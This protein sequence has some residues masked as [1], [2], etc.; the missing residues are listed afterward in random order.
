MQSFGSK[1]AAA[2]SA[3]GKAASVALGAASTAAVAF[4]TNAVGVGKQFDE[5]MANVASISGAT[6]NAL[7]SLREKAIEMGGST[8]FSATEAADAMGYMAMAGWKTGDMLDGISGIMNLAAA[9]GTDLATTADI[10]TDALTAFGLSA[11]DSGH[12]ADVL[13][14][15]S[16]NA[17]TNVQMMG[18]TFKYV[19]PLAGALGLTAEDVAEAVGLMA[20]AGIKASQAGTALRA[21]LTRLTKPTGDMIPLMEKLGLAVSELSGEEAEAQTKA[22][23]ESLKAKQRAYEDDYDAL[24]ESL[25]KQSDALRKSLESR[26]DAQKEAFDNE[27][28][29]RKAAQDKSYDALE[30]ELDAEV[31]A[32]E[33]AQSQRLTEVEKA[34]EA[35]VRAHED[36]LEKKLALIDAEYTESLRLTNEAEYNRLKALDDQIAAIEAESEREQKAAEAAE[37]AQ[38]RAELQK[39]VNTAKNAEERQKAEQK[40]ADYNESI[41]RKDAEAARKAR[42]TDLKAQ[43]DAAKEEAKAERDAAREKR[44]AKEKAEKEA[45]AAELKQIKERQKNDLAELKDGQKR[46]LEQLKDSNKDKLA[47]RKSADA[48]ALKE[49]KKAQSEQ[50]ASLKDANDERLAEVK[51]AYAGELENLKESNKDKLA[52]YKAYIE[53]Q[54]KAVKAAASSAQSLVLTDENGNMRS[55]NEAV[56]ILREAFS[57]LSEAEQAEAAATLFGQ[58]AMSGWLAMLNAAPGDIEKLENALRDCEGAAADMAA[59]HENSLAGSLTTL[60]SALETLKIRISDRLTPTLRAFTEFAQNSIVTLTK[61]FE[62]GD[63]SG[64][65]D[66]LGPVIEDG[67]GMLMGYIPNVVEVG[68][69]LLGAVVTGII[70]NLPVLADGAVKLAT[71]FGGYL[72]NSAPSIIEKGGELLDFFA[73]GI[74]D[75]VDSLVDTAANLIDRFAGFLGDAIPAIAEKA[76]DIV[77]ALTNALADPNTLESLAQSALMIIGALSSAMIA[78]LPRIGEAALNFVRSFAEMISGHTD[79]LADT[80]LNLIDMFAEFLGD[81]IPNLAASAV[82]VIVALAETLSD[83]AVLSNLTQSGLA[84]LEGISTAII[85]NL[86]R[87]AKAA[88]HVVANLG[89]FIIANLPGLFETAK[90]IVIGL[91]EMI[92]RNGPEL[93]RYAARIARDFFGYLYQ[94]FREILDNFGLLEGFDGIIGGISAVFSEI[95]ETAQRVF[96]EVRDAVIGALDRIR[97]ALA[98]VAEILFNLVSGFGEYVSGGDAANTVSNLLSSAIEILGKAIEIAADFLATVVEKISAFIVWLSEGSTGADL[99]TAAVTGVV[100]AF[101]AFKA[102]LAINTLIGTFTKVIDGAKLAFAGFNAIMAANPLILVAT[103]VAGV[104]AALVVLWNTNEDFR[105]AVKEIWAAITGFFSDAWEAIKKVWE[106]A[107]DYF[108]RIWEDIETIFS[109][110]APVF[111]AIFSAAWENVKRIWSVAVFFF[112][113]VWGGIKFTF[114]VA[115]AVIGGFF[116]TAWAAIVLVWDAATGYFENIWNT[117]AGIFSAVESVLKGDFS[118]AWTAIQDVFSGWS[119]YFS[120]LWNDLTNVF[121]N[122]FDWFRGVVENIVN[123][124]IEGVGG[125]WDG[126]LTLIGV[127]TDEV[128]EK[129]EGPEGFDEHSP[130]KWSE[131]VFRRILEG[132]KIGFDKG[133]PGI[134]SSAEGA[135]HDIQNA[136]SADPFSVSGGYN[137]SGGYNYAQPPQLA[138]ATARGTPNYGQSF[139]PAPVNITMVNDVGGDKYE[140]LQYQYRAAED[141]R[142]GPSLVNL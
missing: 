111:E 54:K 36:A 56:G 100:A 51:K 50:L 75:N 21:G 110:A 15:A 8:K 41:R 137:L 55:L 22:L 29:A 1:A 105:N 73:D 49:L 27:Y 31:T 25:E 126:F 38:R 19:A 131:D 82:T 121:S 138:A 104:T 97:T 3:V 132:G 70:N 113:T 47:E 93:L 115:E 64:M 95:S 33:R 84:I 63:F 18:E 13:A 79:E 60:G 85:E 125:L 94:A 98:P 116:S 57:G 80:A 96:P 81:A 4:G 16:S 120:G 9:S 43:K 88:L 66:A 39:A 30:K 122:A 72:L 53:E 117:V 45:S 10:V 46:E 83:P 6:G 129:F 119:D 133:L 14:V 136:L 130:S 40:L 65:M 32:V 90:D 114:S 52:E 48:Q 62:K 78:N 102:A 112:E 58:E 89:A 42:I 2:L 87:L 7:N 124:L 123:G 28:D 142:R 74:L 71:A 101:V 20:N 134:L 12:F 35:E 76:T 37:R 128:K 92:V 11:S 67:I 99:F 34:Q 108:G 141:A 103:L 61:A 86:P 23:E 91:G 68:G 107:A 77:T 5:A 44:D 135:V 127:K 140:R 69:K 109:V 24:R 26:Y 118:G 59:V 106:P 139:R 17:N